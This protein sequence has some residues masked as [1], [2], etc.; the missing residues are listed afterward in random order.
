MTF[1]TFV[2]LVA[3]PLFLGLLLW[4]TSRLE[5]VADARPQ[6]AVE[7]VPAEPTLEAEPTAA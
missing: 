4:L 3:V 6:P 1:T 2:L 7:A 5:R